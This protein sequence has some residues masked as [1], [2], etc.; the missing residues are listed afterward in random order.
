MADELDGRIQEVERSL[1]T[2][3]SQVREQLARTQSGTRT[4]LVVGIILI[5]IIFVYL[6]ILTSRLKPLTDPKE[7][8]RDVQDMT[9]AHIMPSLEKSLKDA[10]PEIVQN[11]REEAVAAIPAVGKMAESKALSFMD[12][13]ADKLSAGT[14]EYVQKMLQKHAAEL[15]PLVQAA[16]T[17]GDP[18]ELRKEFTKDLDA[19]IGGQ[20]DGLLNNFDGAMDMVQHRVDRLLL[21]D[22]Q[23]TADERLEKEMVTSLMFFLNDTLTVP[24]PE[25]PEV[26]APAAGVGHPPAQREAPAHRQAPAR[27]AT[28]PEHRGPEAPAK[29]APQGT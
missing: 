11:L 5:A 2:L 25:A 4:M 18:E 14:D 10:A 19:L 9:S 16:A 21:P 7:L 23:L 15:K 20:V 27:R 17:P 22:K 12:Q 1:T 13:M 29:P 3:E 26:T 8:A 6:T 28:A 24:T